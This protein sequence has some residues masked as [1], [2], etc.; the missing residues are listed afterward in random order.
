MGSQLAEE[1]FHQQPERQNGSEDDRDGRDERQHPLVE[2][3]VRSFYE[4]IA[5]LF[6]RWVAR[7]A[8]PHT[9]RAYR[10]GVMDFVKFMAT[11]GH[12]AVDGSR[13]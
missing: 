10:Q 7:R 8:S 1:V 12:E 2:L 13:C 9:Q 6:E 5:D 3:Q 4:S 11:G